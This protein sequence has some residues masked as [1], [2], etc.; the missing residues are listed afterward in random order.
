MN[1]SNQPHKTRWTEAATEE[2]RRRWIAGESGQQIAN[3]LHTTRSSVLGKVSREGLLNRPG[4]RVE[5][6]QATAMKKRM[7][8]DRAT[9]RRVARMTMP[10]AHPPNKPIPETK[11]QPAMAPGIVVSIMQVGY[12]KCRWPYGDPQ[13]PEFGY[14]GEPS[15]ER[16]YCD[17]HARVAYQPAKTRRNVQG[18]RR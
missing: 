14:C 15:G 2:L 17:C 11:H 10:K 4:R 9:E 8:G 12:G 18:R 7:A 13:L 1:L 5:T 16:S 6:D 3:A